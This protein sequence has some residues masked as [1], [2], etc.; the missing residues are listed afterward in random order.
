MAK[1]ER[2]GNTDGLSKIVE[3]PVDQRITGDERDFCI[4][5]YR[6]GN[7][8]LAA[9]ASGYKG[10]QASRFGT[11]LL[12]TKRIRDY[13]K[14]VTEVHEEYAD[15]HRQQFVDGLKIVSK[16]HIGDFLDGGWDKLKDMKDI[17]E[18]KLHAV[19]EVNINEVYD[20]DGNH[21]KTTTNIKLVD[22]FKYLDML[23]K[24]QNYYSDHNKKE[25]KVIVKIG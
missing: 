6:T 22:K 17:P 1:Q 11:K 9:E 24:I 8:K 13:I 20:R 10:L 14:A 12:E 21:I 2:K 5:Y 7:A 18:E 4:E 3:L 25:S 19:R 15:M 16:T 23:A